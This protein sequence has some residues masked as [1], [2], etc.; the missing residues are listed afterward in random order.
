MS[1]AVRWLRMHKSLTIRY[2]SFGGKERILT[3]DPEVFRHILVTNEKNY[4][5]V[6]PQSPIL[7][8]MGNAL[9]FLSGDLHHSVRKL[10]NP[11]FGLK[12]LENMMPVFEEKV[13][14]V[15][16]IWT[17]QLSEAGSD[18]V[19]IPVQEF[20]TRVA[21]DSLCT[22]GLD[23]DLDAIGHPDDA[24]VKKLTKYLRQVGGAS[25]LRSLLPFYNYL[26][27]SKNRERWREEKFI[28]HLI[29]QRITEKRKQYTDNQST[30]DNARDFLS[31]LVLARDEDGKP[32]PDELL[33]ENVAGLLFA[34]FDTTSIT[35]TWIMLHMALYPD[36]QTRVREEISNCIPS[37]SKVITS[38]ML[39]QLHLLSCVIKE[40][41][42]L[43]P[44][45]SNTT[46]EAL[47]DDSIEG[48]VIPAGSQ[49]VLHLG[50]LHRMDENWEKADKF[51][52]E[53]F[54]DHAKLFHHLPFIAGKYMCI[55]HK[56]AT[57]EMK[58]VLIYLLREFEFSLVPGYKFRRIQA[59]SVKPH[60]DLVLN[61]KKVVLD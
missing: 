25:L 41:Q 42:R 49:I 45:V 43:Y 4:V 48:L 7:N 27:T 29:N 40:T 18:R 50:A 8:L 53:R 46:R 52:P 59:L 36:V 38:G 39:D 26:P 23:H 57:L 56:F 3:A 15:V 24:G 17:Q 34:G 5:R 20:M 9:F 13:K 12:I 51:L 60:P 47:Q 2:Y 35:L 32:I 55:G 19:Q 44:V 1:T 22:T 33:F 37:E 61:V 21:L 31:L 54:M 6:K 16:E 11:A 30:D 10:L 58:I 28:T 14:K